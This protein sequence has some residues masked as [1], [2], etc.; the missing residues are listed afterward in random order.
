MKIF[1]QF[2]HGSLDRVG[3][4]LTDAMYRQ[5]PKWTVA[6]ISEYD[7]AFFSGLV[8]AVKPRKIVEVGVASGWGSVMLLKALEAAGVEDHHYIGVDIAE[9]FFY[10]AN[11]AT[12]QAVGEVVP[13]LASRYH[14]LTGRSIAEVAPELGGGIDFAFIDAH[15]MHPWATLDLLSLLPFLVPGT[16]VAMHDLNLCRK[17]DQ[18]HRNRGPKYLFDA[19]DD[20]RAHSVQVPTMAGAIRIG[21]K[22]E[23]H[24]PL[25]L[26]VL[27]T[28]WELPVEERFLAPL[29][30][31]LTK[32]YGDEWGAKF[33][34]A[35]EV[36]NYLSNKM[37]SRD[38][39]ALTADISRLRNSAS[40]KI[41]GFISRFSQ[42]FGR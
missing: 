37:H 32:H 23:D 29:V 24:L 15:H 6:S 34:H 8:M 26:D 22:P 28:P 25:L 33:Q 36:G 12:G 3:Q 20:D 1:E 18:E 2:S 38:I 4:P 21:A 39:D 5:R 35:T 42:R 30:A 41:G 40:V 27:Y 31:M 16:W 17:E 10:D 13:S 11:Y 14:L 19:W 9:R 7:A